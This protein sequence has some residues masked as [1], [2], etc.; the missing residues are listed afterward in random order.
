[1]NSD[2]N[3]FI[4]CRLTE[5]VQVVLFTDLMAKFSITSNEAKAAMY[6]F[7]NATTS[8]VHCVIVCGYKSGLIRIVDDLEK[9]EDDDS[10]LDAFIY[11]FNPMDQFVPVNSMTKRP[12]A[13]SNC[14]ELAVETAVPSGTNMETKM[15]SETIN[16]GPNKRPTV[17]SQTLP[18]RLTGSR[19]QS[20]AATKLQPKPAVKNTGELRSTALLQKMRKER[21]DKERRRQDELRK[22]RKMQQD[23]VN[24]DPKRKQELEELSAMFDSDEEEGDAEGKQPRSDPPSTNDAN[25]FPSET[26]KPTEA[27]LGELL[28]TTA[29]ESL[30]EIKPPSRNQRAAD[31]EPDKQGDEPQTYLDEEGYTVT[32]RPA[33]RASSTPVKRSARIVPNISES[34]SKKPKQQSLMN[35]FNKRK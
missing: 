17:R 7:Y 1:M 4:H 20:P 9:F 29:E 10:I 19:P 14:Y 33:Q 2:I 8:K 25:F 3:K 18:S 13:V 27:E 34:V 6:D 15:G 11:A 23:K 32:Q 28:E 26:A 30:V 5:D 31:E 21:E 24:N 16:T 35:F 22:R 12:V